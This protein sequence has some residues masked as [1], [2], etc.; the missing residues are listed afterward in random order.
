MS[1]FTCEHPLQ[2]NKRYKGLPGGYVRIIPC[3][4]C[5]GCLSRK[6]SDWFIRLLSEYDH[7]ESAV[8]FTLTYDDE[9]L[10]QNYEVSYE[11]VWNFVRRVKKK[12]PKVR[13]FIVS[14]YG[15]KTS[16]PHYHGFFF[17]LPIDEQKQDNFQAYLHGLWDRG[18]V[19]VGTPSYRRFNYVVKYCL[20]LSESFTSRAKPF[21]CCNRHPA[22]GS[23]F[24][25]DAMVRY[26]KENSLLSINYHGFIRPLPK[27]YR[28]RI[29]TQF[30]LAQIR[31]KQ[32]QKND[33]E[34]EKFI[35][36]L[37]S[38]P[39]S[40]A[41]QKLE[42]IEQSRVQAKRIQKKYIKKQLF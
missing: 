9:K 18:F 17:N 28:D 33:L 10:P 35:S 7:A 8:F 32:K 23:C 41:E 6:R 40:V 22:I 5:V 4:K 12:V 26:I 34:H 21:L 39:D 13:Y 14:E 15:S 37:R 24:M 25:S 38:L 20:A 29:F 27:Y 30:E 19:T 1:A 36:L 42:L 16:R 3:G 2:L 11:D 31:G